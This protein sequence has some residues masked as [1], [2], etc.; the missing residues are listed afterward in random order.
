MTLELKNVSKRVGADMHIHDTSLV[1]QDNSFNILLGA[2]RAGKTTLMQ[3]MAG[4]QKPTTG[5]IWHR[6]KDVTHVPV[7]RR[8]VSMVYQQFI[9]Y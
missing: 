3:L 7:Q 6:G 4:I 2:T 5:A 1:F 8:N 9:N